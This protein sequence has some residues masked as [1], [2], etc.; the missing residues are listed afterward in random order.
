MRRNWLASMVLTAVACFSASVFAAPIVT[1]TE[2]VTN[3]I[4]VDIPTSA[5]PIAIASDGN[6]PFDP[7]LIGVDISDGIVLNSGWLPDLSYPS[8]AFSPGFWSQIPGTDTWI[9]PAATPAGIENEPN[10]EPIGQW[11]FPGGAWDMANTPDAVWLLEPD[12]SLSDVITLGNF[13]PDGSAALRFDS[14][15]FTVPEP[16]TLAP[17]ALGLVG[18]GWCRRRRV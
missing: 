12:G 4:F 6:G 9:L 16:T 14:D 2:D 1:F 13:G 3:G 8:L 11:Y 17:A 15:P 5:P 18:M 7:F 10:F